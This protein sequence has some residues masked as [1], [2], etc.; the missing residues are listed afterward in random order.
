L[1]ALKDLG[2]NVITYVCAIFLNIT[3]KE[4]KK[5]KR[6]EVNGQRRGGKRMRDYDT[7][8]IILCCRISAAFLYY[9]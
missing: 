6:K 1:L 3:Q 5:Y 9:F 7:K 2:E 4:R 8:E